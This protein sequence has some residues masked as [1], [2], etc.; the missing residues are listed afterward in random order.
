MCVQHGHAGDLQQ[1]ALIARGRPLALGRL[2]A[3]SGG[4]VDFAA[5]PP[6]DMAALRDAEG[7]LTLLGKKKDNFGSE[8]WL[9][10]DADARTGAEHS[11][12]CDKIGCVGLLPNGE[13]AAL[14][15]DAAAFHEDCARAQIVISPLYAPRS[16]NPQILLDR[17]RLAETGAVTLTFT[18][19]GGV[20]WRTA[21]A[22]GEDRPWSRAPRL[23]LAHILPE[24]V[25]PPDDEPDDEPLD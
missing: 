13:T 9:R 6:G 7:Q 11:G 8:Q 23:R 24:V 15:L 21:R 1:H 20:V 2:G 18:E 17:A 19:Q 4:R 25:T 16:C 22:P 12:R 3:A 14:V 10:A 5:P